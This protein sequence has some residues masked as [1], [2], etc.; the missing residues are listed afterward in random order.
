M[1]KP[2]HNCIFAQSEKLIAMDEKDKRFMRRAI[3]LAKE[4]MDSGTGGPF[5]AVVVKNNKIIGE[6]C[7]RVTSENDPT[8]H[9]EIVAIR[10]A[11]NQLGVFELKG[12][13]LYTSCEPCPMC[14]GAIYWAHPDEVFYA[15]TI[16]D[17]AKINFDD[18]YIYDEIGKTPDER[19]IPF[20]NV[21][22]N[23]GLL[24]FEKWDIKP[25]KTNY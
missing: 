14:L 5:G 13:T 12:C 10:D 25:D 1:K 6:G 3:D 11:C 22:R 8:A 18:R 16:D 24:L 17:A 4:G 2:V 19:Q 15:C 7:N 9:A 20:K 23:E 21:L